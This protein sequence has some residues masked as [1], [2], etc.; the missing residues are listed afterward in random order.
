M[1]DPGSDMRTLV[2]QIAQALVDAPADVVEACIC[3]RPRLG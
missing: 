3:S 2:E 1:S